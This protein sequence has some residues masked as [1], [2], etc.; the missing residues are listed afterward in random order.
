M[1]AGEN[2]EFG[3]PEIQL[4]LIPGG[5]GTQLL[6]RLIG[7]QR[8]ME[9]VLTGKRITAEEALELGLLNRVAGKRDWLDEA[10]EL[11]Q[12][13][14]ARPPEAARLAKQAVLAA[15]E[16]TLAGGI[17]EER[18]LRRLAATTEDHVEALQALLERR[19]PEFHGR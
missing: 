6:T 2:A 15:E 5:G 18:R 8:A 3:H 13:V 9:L 14:A 19:R 17:A 4:G 10:V 7:K 1:V 11:A 12:V 16:T